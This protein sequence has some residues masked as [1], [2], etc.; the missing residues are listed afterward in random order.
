MVVVNY[1]KASRPQSALV[2]E[3]EVDR[4]AQFTHPRPNTGCSEE[5]QLEIKAWTRAY[6]Q[7]CQQVIRNFPEIVQQECAKAHPIDLIL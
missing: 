6:L 4:Q 3:F 5:Q 7:R 2:A 1:W